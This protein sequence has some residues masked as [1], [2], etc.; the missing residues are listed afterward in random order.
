MPE[1]RSLRRTGLLLLAACLCKTEGNLCYY[2][3]SRSLLQVLGQCQELGMPLQFWWDEAE[4]KLDGQFCV[5][6]CPQ[7]FTAEQMQCVLPLPEG[8][9]RSPAAP[10]PEVVPLPSK[11]SAVT[12]LLK[13]PLCGSAEE[14]WTVM[15]EARLRIGILFQIPMSEV[16]VDVLKCPANGAA[17][18]NGQLGDMSVSCT[19]D[20]ESLRAEGTEGPSSTQ[21]RVVAAWEQEDWLAVA[22][23]RLFSD[24]SCQKLLPQPLPPAEAVEALGDSSRGFAAAALAFDGNRSSAFSHR[25]Q[26]VGKC[27]VKAGEAYLEVHYVVAQ[28][29]KC[30]EISWLAPKPKDDASPAVPL[31]VLQSKDG[32]GRWADA[33][34]WRGAV[35]PDACHGVEC[36][37]YGT[38]QLPEGSGSGFCKCF[39]GFAGARC[40]EYRGERGLSPL[41]FDRV[42]GSFPPDFTQSFAS[43]A[44]LCGQRC[45]DEPG[46]QSW[47][48]NPWSLACR[49]STWARSCKEPS[50]EEGWG[51]FELHNGQVHAPHIPNSSMHACSAEGRAQ[52]NPY[53][54]LVRV[55]SARTINETLRRK[56]ERLEP[57]VEP[58][59]GFPAKLLSAGS[60]LTHEQ[61]S[62]L[63]PTGTAL[64]LFSQPRAMYFGLHAAGYWSVDHVVKKNRRRHLVEVL[65]AGDGNV[66]L[67]SAVSPWS[68]LKATRLNDKVVKCEAKPAPEDRFLSDGYL[69]R[70]KGAA[71]ANSEA[72]QLMGVALVSVAYGLMLEV[73]ADGS[74]TFEVPWPVPARN[75]SRQQVFHVHEQ[76]LLEAATALSFGDVAGPSSSPIFDQEAVRLTAETGVS[77]TED[78]SF[79]H[80]AESSPLAWIGITQTQ[81]TL[82][83][84]FQFG[85]WR[86]PSWLTAGTVVNPEAA[87]ASSAEGAGE[88]TSLGV[89]VSNLEKAATE[90]LNGSRNSTVPLVETTESASM[91]KASQVAFDPLPT[92]LGA[93]LLSASLILLGSLIA[94][95]FWGTC[96]QNVVRQEE[97]GKVLG[98]WRPRAIANGPSWAP[99]RAGQ[100]VIAAEPASS[101]TDGSTSACPDDQSAGRIRS[102]AALVQGP[103]GAPQLASDAWEGNERP[104]QLLAVGQR[105]SPSDSRTLAEL[106]SGSRPLNADASSPMS[107]TWQGSSFPNG[108]SQHPSSPSRRQR[109]NSSTASSIATEDL[110]EDDPLNLSSMSLMGSTSLSWTAGLSAASLADRAAEK[111]RI[112]AAAMSPTSGDAAAKAE[113][114]A[115]REARQERVK[116][117]VRELR[118]T[119]REDRTNG[120][121]LA[122]RQERLNRWREDWDPSRSN[123]KIATAIVNFLGEA[124]GWYLKG[125]PAK[126]E[127]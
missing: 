23:L 71:F 94:W 119:M 27:S 88:R 37:S 41:I 118:E 18:T 50:K 99:R 93:T 7:G 32:Q 75:V 101:P 17:A 49:T 76:S 69:F 83:E 116:S 123:D 46:C 15:A 33:A 58:L 109:L 117:T 54:L 104:E 13:A 80:A 38:C 67:R 82:P 20:E 51:F 95:L 65:D 110:P 81:T 97:G 120:T 61:P 19:F 22:E 34:I 21:W 68:F 89:G 111:R 90:D 127:A 74:C 57:L 2:K 6:E 108:G 113:R 43:R 102:L 78:W 70:A 29:V 24:A 112:A 35:P 91:R 84:L 122:E 10:G 114:A 64:G 85:V 39:E 40:E 4:N 59:M 96:R 11:S 1:Q 30:A 121:P 73:A 77:V 16:R 52:E 26:S 53:V 47:A 42:P 28:S 5:S 8:F 125:A 72:G 63:L 79:V 25:C 100:H 86:K 14:R 106:P 12:F 56:A 66:V 87:T 105:Q 45:L 31:W 126:Q 3:K 62:G 92:W 98:G 60:A 103:P 107:G 48:Y 115:E 44:A 36:G 124:E 55:V 9:R